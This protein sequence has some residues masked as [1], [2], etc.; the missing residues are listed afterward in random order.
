MPLSDTVCR[1]AKAGAAPRKLADS[2]G[3]YLYVSTSGAR[4]WRLDYRLAGKRRTVSFGTYPTVSLADARRARDQAK[5]LLA[6]GVDP[7][8]HKRATREAA[9]AVVENT[10]GAIAKE[11]AGKCEGR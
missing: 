2:L 7:S 1:S 11:Y 4:S 3:L 5:K 8:D 6:A 9:R 10:F